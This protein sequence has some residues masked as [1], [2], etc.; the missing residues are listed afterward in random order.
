MS[1]L[2]DKEIEAIDPG[3]YYN[4][5]N[6]AR[7]IEQAVI[8]KLAAV[9]VEP[10]GETIGVGV[11]RWA[12]YY[13]TAGTKLYT[14][15]AIA[16]ARVQ[17]EQDAIKRL[18]EEVS[19]EPCAW[20]DADENE[21][22]IHA[23]EKD[24]KFAYTKRYDL[25]LYTHEAIAAARVQALSEAAKVADKAANSSSVDYIGVGVASLAQRIRALI[26]GQ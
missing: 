11:I 14:A 17:G 12:R 19:V 7:A 26:G 18:S 21:S 6:F 5:I 4:G 8:A 22:I 24:H 2:T 1:L 20:M 3:K 15:E 23:F 13:P 25:P 10:F 16:A 9:S